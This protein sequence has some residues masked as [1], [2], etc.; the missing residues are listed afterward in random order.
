MSRC[1]SGRFGPGLK[2]LPV[3]PKPRPQLANP[4][5]TK[6]EFVGDGRSRFP[7]CQGL[8]DPPLLPGK[9]AQ[10]RPQID[11]GRRR[12]GWTGSSIFDEQVI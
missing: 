1:T 10:P 11:S 6:A 2:L 9:R 5:G 3:L 8:S 4:S 12:L 7:Q